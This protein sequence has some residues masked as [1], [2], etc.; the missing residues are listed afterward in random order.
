MNLLR[1]R[2]TGKFVNRRRLQAEL[3]ESI[4]TL[5]ADDETT[6]VVKKRFSFPKDSV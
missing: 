5:A 4:M 6:S 2:S 3:N 1:G